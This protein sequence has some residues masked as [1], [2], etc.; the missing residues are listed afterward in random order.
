MDLALPLVATSDDHLLDVALRWCAAVGCTPEVAADVASA[1]R[2]WRSAP[3]VVVGDDLAPQLARA[4]LPRRDHVLM[5]AGSRDGAW[6]LAVALGAVDV[7]THDDEVRALHALT[8]ALDGRGEA[9]LVSVVGGCGGAGASTLAACL[10]LAG[11]EAGLR[12]LVLDADPIGGGL[13][14]L[15]GTE[16]RDGLRWQDLGA[17]D[18]PVG[19]ASLAA[20]L[21][22]TGDLAVLSWGRE[23]TEDVPQAVG[24]VLT[25]AIRGFDLVVADVPRHLGAA[26]AE[27]VGRSVL[28]VL[29]VP[30]D[31]RAIAASRRVLDRLRPHTSSFAVVAVA[32]ANGLGRESVSDALALPVVARLRHDRHL[33]PAVDL[34]H[35]PGESRTF[36]RASDQLIELLG[37]ESLL[38]PPVAT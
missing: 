27:L 23:G 26:G 10:A 24:G 7:V 16:D 12:S 17:T 33:R 21:P 1:R 32:R 22:R 18:G 5:L 11:S 37:L 20:V 8:L 14:L 6:P 30:E 35:G 31:I 9:C 15:L 19:A 2:S 34:G 28:T 13:D 38:V 29:V 25:A 4:E 36:R 3:V